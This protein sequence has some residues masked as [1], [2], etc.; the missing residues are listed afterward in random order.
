VSDK[1]PISKRL[2][3]RCGDACAPRRWTTTRS[4]SRSMFCARAEALGRGSIVIRVRALPAAP[5]NSERASLCRVWP[6][7][8]S[9][10]LCSS[11][12]LLP[13]DDPHT[14][15]APHGRAPGHRDGAL[16][17]SINVDARTLQPIESCSQHFR[18]HR[19]SG[20]AECAIGIGQNGAVTAG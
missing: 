14:S 19:L 1:L 15:V 2:W 18:A 10:S 3:C 9:P 20:Q 4:K 12:R 7:W 13:C 17:N 8:P 16:V 5:Q 6:A 11:R